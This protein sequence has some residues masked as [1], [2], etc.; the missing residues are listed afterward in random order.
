MLSDDI[1]SGRQAVRKAVTLAILAQ[2]TNRV[3]VV[4][5]FC[6]LGTHPHHTFG[7]TRSISSLGLALRLARIHQAR[8]H[9]AVFLAT[10][11]NPIA[12]S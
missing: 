4:T 11:L 3:A 9:A 7:S 2:G 12:I 6:C 10:R 5:F 1:M 8:L